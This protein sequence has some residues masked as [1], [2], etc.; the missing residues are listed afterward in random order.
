MLRTCDEVVRHVLRPRG[1]LSRD[2]VRGSAAL[3]SSSAKRSSD[4][5][6]SRRSMAPSMLAREQA[7]FT[8]TA[9][10]LI[11]PC[12]ANPCGH[13]EEVPTILRILCVLLHRA[14]QRAQ[15]ACSST[16]MVPGLLCGKVA[17]LVH[18]ESTSEFFSYLAPT[19][20]YDCQQQLPPLPPLPPLPRAGRP[21]SLPIALADEAYLHRAALPRDVKYVALDARLDAP[22]QRRAAAPGDSSKKPSRLP[23]GVPPSVS[24]A[25]PQ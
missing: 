23:C 5:I 12:T 11:C 22:G 3:V 14:Q 4:T 7:P 9:S 1:A 16:L 6:Q 10:A 2:S 21:G 8:L 24:R 19:A 17:S 25:P 18:E 15:A 20:I 13:V